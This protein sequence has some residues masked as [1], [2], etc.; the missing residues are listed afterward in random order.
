MSD[1]SQDYVRIFDTTL[2]DGEQSPGAAMTTS[3]KLEVARVLA[4]LGVDVIEAGFPAASNDDFRAVRS[5]AEEVGVRAVAGRGRPASRRSSARL[6]RASTLDIDRA[7][8]A[9]KVAA[10]PR[11]HT[12]LATSDLHL[13]HKLRMTRAEALERARVMVA[14]ARGLCDDV[15][16]SAEDATRSDPAFLYDV[17]AAAIRAGATTINVPDTVGYATP[18]ELALLVAGVRANVPGAERVILSVHCHDDLG[19]AT[20]NSLAGLRAGAR[21]VE[22]TMNGIGER[23]GNASL[24]EVVMSLRTRA[25]VFGLH[26]GIDATQ[27]LRASKR[28][29]RAAP[30]WPSS[31]TRRSWGRTPSRTRAGSTRTGSSRTSGPTRS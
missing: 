14:Y 4:R 29:Q 6:A 17:I 22:V 16:F 7:W 12:F 31:R 15:E 28:G 18:D 11:I 8:E 5:I 21:Q 3:E 24:E 26:T 20:A 2:R 9:V 23:A 1:Q 27:L 10:R 30:G 13:E 25:P 19:M